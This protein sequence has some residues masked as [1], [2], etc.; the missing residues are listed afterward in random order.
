MKLI[1]QIWF[2][3]CTFW[4]FANFHETLDKFKKNDTDFAYHYMH[5][6]CRFFEFVESFIKI[7]EKSLKMQNKKTEIV[8]SISLSFFML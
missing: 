8:K 5:N 4:R 2:L 1:L 7:S 3:F 6:L